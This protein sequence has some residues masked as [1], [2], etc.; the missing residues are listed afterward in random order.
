MGAMAPAP[1]AG[2]DRRCIL[3]FDIDCFY[4]QAEELRRPELA[5]KPLAV[6]QKY[7]IVTCNY[8]AR[9][10]GVTKL[11]GTAEGLKHCPRLVLVNGEDL[12]P[13]RAA[14]KAVAAALRRFGPTE[15]LGL[16]EFF[17]DASEAV[18]ARVRGGGGAPPPHG[19]RGHVQSGSAAV[20]ADS[21]HRPQDLRAPPGQARAGAVARGAGEAG[22][23]GQQGQQGS[24]VPWGQQ[25]GGAGD[26]PAAGLEAGQ[27]SEQQ[28]QEQEQQE[29]P[30]PWVA[31][32]M[33][34]SA[35]AE[36]ARAAVRAETGFRCSAGI[37][38]NKMLAKLVS[39]VHKPNDQTILPPGEAWAFLEPLPVRALPGI[40]HR[41]AEQLGELGAATV[42]E[43]RRLPLAL[44]AAR[45]PGE[46]SG[47][48]VHGLARGTDPSPVRP[49]GPPKS[50]TTED[51][52]S[53]CDTWDGVRSVLQVLV[54]DLLA[55]VHEE[56]L[57]HRRRPR[58]L[59]VK[60]RKKGAGWQ[61]SS[62]S[63]PLPLPGPLA[64][65][66]GPGEVAAVVRAAAQL[67][68]Q[69]LPGPF[70]L[71]LIN[72][73]VTS[74]KEEG[75]GAG[76]YDVAAFQRLLSGGGGGARG[77]GG[78]GSRAA[79]GDGGG[80]GGSGAE[81][82]AAAPGRGPP[83]A[84]NLA[85]PPQAAA[86]GAGI[87]AWARELAAATAAAGRPGSN[88]PG[89]A[90]AA[91]AA[92]EQRRDY[93]KSPNGGAAAAPISKSEERRLREQGGGG[94][95]FAA[96]ARRLEAAALPPGERTA[97]R[98]AEAPAAAAPPAKLPRTGLEGASAQRQCIDQ[99][100]QQQQQQ[101]QPEQQPEQHRQQEQEREEQPPSTA[102]PGPGGFDIVTLCGG[103][104]GTVQVLEEDWASDPSD[105]EGEGG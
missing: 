75:P 15:R 82:G 51:S 11:M 62:A 79:G 21:R 23:G 61:R 40:G 92:W 103:V 37:S 91:A 17:V 36:E 54:P 69:Q 39:G 30:P 3:H 2:D 38:V 90:A 28:Q 102:S 89:A 55:R 84:S 104:F 5:G 65:P 33:S 41:L 57:E 52:F 80:G 64:A 22:G 95:A 99:Q 26:W 53:G 7:L 42:A 67:L 98:A 12:T 83:A 31:R 77:G 101:Q 78:A 94:Q 45:L 35:I 48:M 25:E 18:A 58:T 27:R 32:L 71:S 63:A 50:I 97:R 10:A 85:A 24:G 100:Q 34:G 105:D 96:A 19:W 59:T 88:D 60:W 4:A 49:S 70:N 1:T 9:A 44:L 74:F 47:A 8:A 43:L 16:D 6:T 73:G 93:R 56:W 76:A 20:V 14:S 68:K 86:A 72:V 81:P 87:P 46:A 29:P 66:P 13:Y